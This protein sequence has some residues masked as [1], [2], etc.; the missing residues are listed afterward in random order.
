MLQS[1]G[2][3]RIRHDLSTKQQQLTEHRLGPGSELSAGGTAAN[4][5]DLKTWPLSSSGLQYRE[6]N[7]KKTKGAGETV[8]EK[9]YSSEEAFQVSQKT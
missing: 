2:L 1:M 7:R 5:R 6:G 8:G 9:K 4:Q 3:Q